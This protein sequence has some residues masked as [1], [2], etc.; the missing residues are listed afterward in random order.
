[1][2]SVFL[3]HVNNAQLVLFR[4]S[5]LY[6]SPFREDVAEEMVPDGMVRVEYLGAHTSH[7]V[8][9]REHVVM[10]GVFSADSGR[11]TPV[12][13]AAD[14]LITT[15]TPVGRVVVRVVPW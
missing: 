6:A 1:M 11:L 14:R 7:D 15:C 10:D 2:G 9:P 13:F 3:G 5:T 8:D 4:Y 12:N